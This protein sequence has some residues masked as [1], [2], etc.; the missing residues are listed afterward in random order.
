MSR[1]RQRG[2]QQQQ[3]RRLA[4]EAARQRVATVCQFAQTQHVPV[5]HVT[6]C[7]SVSDR[8]VRRW[9]RRACAAPLACAATPGRPSQAAN[10]TDRNLVYRFLRERGT[11]TPLAAVQAAFPHLRRVDLQDV[12]RR[13]RHL[14]Q[15]KR[16]RHQ[17]R[18]HWCRAGAVW[19]ADFKERREP[20]EGRYPWILAVKDL[21]SRCQLAWLPVEE[22]TAETVQA[23]YA[24][25]FAEHGPPLVLKSDNGGQFRDD[26]TKQL[27]ANHDVVPLYNPRR[28]PAYNGGVERANGQLAGYQ[29]AVAAAQGRAG[30]PTCGDAEQ[31]RQLANE[32]ARPAGWRGPTAGQLWQQRQ[33]LKAEER[34]SFLTAVAERRLE[35]RAALNFQPA[36]PLSHYP[37]A[38]VDRRAVRDALVAQGLL[39]IE[40]RRRKRASHARSPEQTALAEL[41]KHLPTE[42]AAKGAGRISNASAVAEPTVGAVAVPEFWVEQPGTQ[43]TEEA[44]SS[45]NKSAA[46][47]QD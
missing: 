44:N 12:L 15:K 35:S 21:A 20:I 31:A 14:A 6:R 22:A 10:R 26:R 40:S 30:L 33:P 8:T 39:Q 42:I 3:A 13:C 28:R 32:L 23:T 24:R 25:L 18:L 1:N 9:R 5:V 29:E 7:L 27:L 36:E 41:K 16:Q 45:T 17:S 4:E 38:A 11:G 46:S 43:P 34:A 37:Q 19:A 47:G 2:R